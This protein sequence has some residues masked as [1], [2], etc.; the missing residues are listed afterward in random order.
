MSV[1]HIS[2]VH[3]DKCPHIWQNSRGNDK[4]Y[5]SDKIWTL[6]Y[7]HTDIIPCIVTERSHKQLSSPSSVSKNYL[8][9]L[10]VLANKSQI[11]STK[12]SRKIVICVVFVWGC[13]LFLWLRIIKLIFT[14]R[15]RCFIKAI[16]TEL[17]L[18]T[19]FQFLRIC[20]II[21]KENHIFWSVIL[22]IALSQQ[23]NRISQFI[24]L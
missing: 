5:F 3:S 10:S 7:S 24:V 20:T 15:W 19:L 18:N 4:L 17:L 12:K 13:F 11:F 6:Y 22:H 14:V 21:K 2:I 1:Y 23:H 8:E 16:Q 9:Y